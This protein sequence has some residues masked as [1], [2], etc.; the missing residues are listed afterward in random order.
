MQKD[1]YLVH[2]ETK[3]GLVIKIYQDDDCESPTAWGDNNVFLC[4]YHRD[5]WIEA[6][7]DKFK[8]RIFTKDEVIEIAQKNYKHKDYFVFPI[9][10]YIHG[11]VSL[12]LST[13]GNFP[14]RQ[15]DVSQIGA[16]FIKKTEFKT[17]DKARHCAIG[18]IN[19][20]NDYLSSNVFGYIIEDNQGN[21]LESCWSFYGDYDKD[22]GAL[23]E[24][25]SLVDHL[26]NKGITDHT[27][28]YLM[29]F[30]AN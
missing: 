25:L 5:F 12:A 13:E 1:D 3:N 29:P 11:G 21:H 14:D 27:G 18:L 20:W 15:F 2:E 6:P 7:S 4:A 23:S 9:E 22:G 30:M 16:I 24:A 28:Q 17:K 26:T 10:A 8:D 19:T